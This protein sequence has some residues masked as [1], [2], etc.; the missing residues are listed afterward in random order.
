MITQKDKKVIIK[1]GSCAAAIF[2]FW[3]LIYF[4]AQ[5]RCKALK[6]DFEAVKAQVAAIESR[7]G[8]DGRDIAQMVESLQKDFGRN[9]DK[10]PHAEEGALKLIA[11]EAAKHGV[12][13]IS[14]SPAARRP[15]LDENNNNLFVENIQCFEIPIAL[16]IK[17]SYKSIGEYLRALREDAA[18]LIRVEDINIAKSSTSGQQLDARAEIILTVLG[19]D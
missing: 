14:M 3:A 13:I 10:I 6:S 2:L 1:A 19:Q 4:P 17:G 12:A 18:V 8:R 16:E 7:G 5:K 9:M 11:A 15:M